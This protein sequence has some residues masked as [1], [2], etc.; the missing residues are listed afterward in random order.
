LQ[1]QLDAVEANAKSK[2]DAAAV[3]QD[4]ASYFPAQN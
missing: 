3:A 1:T 4:A 2:L